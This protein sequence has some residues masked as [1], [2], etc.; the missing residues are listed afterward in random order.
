LDLKAI[1]DYTEAIRLMPQQAFLYGSRGHVFIKT[2]EIEKAIND[3]GM[4][5][6]LAPNQHVTY[7]SRGLLFVSEKQ[8]GRALEDFRD[9]SRQGPDD[10]ECH[11]S[12]AWLLATCPDSRF[13]DGKQALAEAT[14]ACTLTGWKNGSCL[15]AMAAASAE[16]G[17][18]DSAVKWQ[19][20]ALD[21]LPKEGEEFL[22]CHRRLSVY[23]IKQPYRD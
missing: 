14:R 20:Q 5:I 16:V 10:F 7:L 11:R 22:R 15:E 19:S 9:A 3:F 21:L 18:F 6:K 13:R 8:F 1:A 12:L 17:D 23:E 4:A 2:R